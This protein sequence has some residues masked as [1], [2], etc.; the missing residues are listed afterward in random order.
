M[1]NL[2]LTEGDITLSIKREKNEESKNV[3]NISISSGLGKATVKLT[4]EEL[5]TVRNHLTGILNEL[6]SE[7]FK[8]F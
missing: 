2:E 3:A 4:K 1:K 5:Q 6:L 8:K 7:E